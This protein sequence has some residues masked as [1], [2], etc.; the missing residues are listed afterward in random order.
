MK[1]VYGHNDWVISSIYPSVLPGSTPPR[2]EQL[3]ILNKPCTFSR[4]DHNDGGSRL[5]PYETLFHAVQDWRKQ[6]EERVSEPQNKALSSLTPLQK[7]IFTGNSSSRAEVKR[8]MSRIIEFIPYHGSAWDALS[9]V[10]IKSNAY[11]MYVSATEMEKQKMDTESQLKPEDRRS[12]RIRQIGM[13]KL[14]RRYPAITPMISSRASQQYIRQIPFSE[15]CSQ[16]GYVRIRDTLS[17]SEMNDVSIGRLN[18]L[19]QAKERADSMY[20]S[21]FSEDIKNPARK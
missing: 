1:Q 9:S 4:P 21:V 19:Q 10:G 6:V 14:V 17:A 15:E 7:C 13:S 16:D 18:S 8:G 12:R 20:Q 2:K 11:E 5:G 3:Q